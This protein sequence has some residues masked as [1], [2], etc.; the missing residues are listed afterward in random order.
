MNQATRLPDSKGQRMPRRVMRCGIP[1]ALLARG[2]DAPLGAGSSGG[3]SGRQNPAASTSRA[4]IAA[5]R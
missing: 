5:A 3:T 1:A 4:A 2:C